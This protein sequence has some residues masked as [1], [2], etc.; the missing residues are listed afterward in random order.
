M[1]LKRLISIGLVIG[2]ALASIYD[3]A[4][5]RTVF[6]AQSSFG[7]FFYIYGQ[8]IG[9]LSGVFALSILTH[10]KPLRFRTLGQRLLYQ[11]FLILLGLGM[12][13]QTHYFAHSDLLAS[14]L[15]SLILT[16]FIYHGVSKF[17]QTQLQALKSYA[18]RG[19]LTLLWVL[20][21]P[22]LLKIVWG[23][24]RYRLVVLDLAN[25]VAWFRPIGQG[26]MDDFKSFPSG[27]TAV[28]AVALWLTCIPTPLFLHSWHAYFLK[29]SVIIW[30]GLVMVSRIILG[31]HYLSDVWMGL[32][33]PLSFLL[34]YKPVKSSR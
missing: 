22:S 29:T 14:I 16:L 10:Q 5:S 20:T 30:I 25:F 1:T 26:W 13:V 28:A 15:I 34:F 7:Q 23:R 19:V 8:S 6:N 24:P 12:G 2:M 32:S 17:T 27:H 4:I 21:V 9:L 18:W 31:D 33:I 3:E 11:S